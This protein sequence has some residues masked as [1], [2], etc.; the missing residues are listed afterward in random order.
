MSINGTPYADL[1]KFAANILS[2]ALNDDLPNGDAF[3]AYNLDTLSVDTKHQDYNRDDKVIDEWFVMVWQCRKRWT[4]TVD[5]LARWIGMLPHRG[6]G[7]YILAEIDATDD[8]TQIV[9]RVVQ[10]VGIKQRTSWRGSGR[11]Q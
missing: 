6:E 11:Y 7:T 3:T 8:Y 4:K 9:V 5:S 1:R 10:P 2:T